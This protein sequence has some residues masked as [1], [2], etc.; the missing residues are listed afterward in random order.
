ML[1]V[2]LEMAVPLLLLAIKHKFRLPSLMM[3]GDQDC[4]SNTKTLEQNQVP[5]QLDLKNS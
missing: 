2:L 1:E 3:L 5:Y 4:L